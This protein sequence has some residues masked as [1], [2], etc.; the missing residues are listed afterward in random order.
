MSILAAIIK[1]NAKGTEYNRMHNPEAY[2]AS[3][4]SCETVVVSY[5]K[6]FL[7]LGTSEWDFSWTQSGTCIQKNMAMKNTPGS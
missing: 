7:Y 3:S 6:P 5:I 4:I 1:T 2:H